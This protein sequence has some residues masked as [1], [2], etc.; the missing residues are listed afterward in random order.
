MV[1]VS[2]RL[3][4]RR[5]VVKSILATRDNALVISGLGSSTY[6]VHAAGDNDKNFYM[7]GGM[8][9]A[10][11][12]GLGLAIAQPEKNIIVFTGDGE[13]LMGLGSLATVS[14]KKPKNL[15]IIV[16]DN[17]HFGETGMQESH[18]FHKVD[19]VGVALASGCSNAILKFGHASL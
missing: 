16:L 8:G 7:W 17:E 2:K 3:L 13:M 18:T 12:I 1:N 11:M 6:D 5:E 14:V 19:L 15:L 4:K 10:A 9:G